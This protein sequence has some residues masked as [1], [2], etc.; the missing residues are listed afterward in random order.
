MGVY[1]KHGA[2]RG[3][4][5]RMGRGCVK[6]EMSDEEMFVRTVGTQHAASASGLA[7]QKCHIFHVSEAFFLEHSSG[8]R[9]MLHSCPNKFL[10]F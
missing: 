8:G 5:W 4:W 10:T 9:S 7:E 1:T 3:L 2:W 6:I